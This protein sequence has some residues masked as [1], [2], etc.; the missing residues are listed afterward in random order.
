MQAHIGFG[1]GSSP[2]ASLLLPGPIAHGAGMV[3]CCL[4]LLL[5]SR[6]SAVDSSNR[7]ICTHKQSPL[8]IPDGHIWLQGD[9]TLN[10]TDSR[11]YG[12]IPYAL[13]EGRAFVKVCVVHRI[14]C[15]IW[16]CTLQQTGVNATDIFFIADLAICRGGMGAAQGVRCLKAERVVQYWPQSFHV[17]EQCL[18]RRSSGGH[19]LLIVFKSI[20][21]P[22]AACRGSAC[23]LLQ[24]LKAF[25]DKHTVCATAPLPNATFI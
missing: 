18:W 9:N 11:H 13:V 2:G 3:Y 4:L 24:V 16:V 8:Q 25:Q 19:S 14:C 5:P 22:E 7:C 6:I 10:S 15:S 12:P 21:A 17:Q 1:R 23:I 20:H